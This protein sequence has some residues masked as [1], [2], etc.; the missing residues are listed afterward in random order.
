MFGPLW[1]YRLVSFG[2]FHLCFHE[3]IWRGNSLTRQGGGKQF[4]VNLVRALKL[5]CY[6]PILVFEWVATLAPFEIRERTVLGSVFQ[7]GNES[8]WSF[9]NNRLQWRRGGQAKEEERQERVIS[10]APTISRKQLPTIF[11]HTV[12]QPQEVS[13]GTKKKNTG[14]ITRV[15][16]ASFYVSSW[17]FFPFYDR[18]GRKTASVENIRLRVKMLC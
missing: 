12:W 11:P 18:P 5:A 10:R 15:Y 1:L 2:G 8:S 6:L 3:S 4:S 7:L 13:R 16:F 14:R 17:F 9:C